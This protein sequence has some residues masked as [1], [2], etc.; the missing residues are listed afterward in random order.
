MFPEILST[1]RKRSRETG[2]TLVEV[3]T[4]LAILGLVIGP[5]SAAAIT[6]MKISSWDAD[7]NFHLRQ[8]QNAGYRILRD[9]L[10]AQTVT[11]TPGVFLSFS[12]TDWDGNNH[13]VNYLLVE[14]TIQRSYNG[15]QPYVVAEQIDTTTTTAQWDNEHG[16]LT[17]TITSLGTRMTR[18]QQVYIVRPRAWVGE[19]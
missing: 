8:V 18:I 1:A 5:T 16:Q 11:T 19:S 3:L 2:F 13:V 17:V 10:M 6:I 15:S 12:W 7:I 14:N 4:A 9:G